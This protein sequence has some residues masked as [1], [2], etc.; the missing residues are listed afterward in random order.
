MATEDFLYHLYRATALLEDGAAREAMVEVESALL[1]EPNDPRARELQERA[2]VRNASGPSSSSGGASVGHPTARSFRAPS[3]PAPSSV[4]NPAAPA[5]ETAPAASLRSL[6]PATGGVN[7]LAE[8]SLRAGTGFNVRVD[9]IRAFT[10]ELGAL[11]ERDEHQ[12]VLLGG[13]T[14]PFVEATGP[15]RLLLSPRSA[16]RIETLNVSAGS[17]AGDHPLFVRED[18]LIAF[19]RSLTHASARV[20]DIQVVQLQGEGQVLVEAMAAL[21]RVRVDADEPMSVRADRALVGW[22]GRLLAH[23]PGADEAPL[24]LR[25]LLRF[26]APGTTGAT[27]GASTGGST[28]PAYLLLAIG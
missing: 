4:S 24:G 28:A 20:G 6:A 23:A 18:A 26:T 17:A 5:A 11:V 8:L 22:T 12:H 2:R 19:D 16:H 21:R 14:H 9:A 15:G 3:S 10:V 7:L 13:A 27:T 25:A 1:H